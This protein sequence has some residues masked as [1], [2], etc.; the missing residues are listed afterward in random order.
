MIIDNDKTCIVSFNLVLP[1]GVALS[2]DVVHSISPEAV[3]VLDDMYLRNNIFVGW[4][5]SPD[6]QISGYSDF[7][8]LDNKTAQSAYWYH[9]LRGT[10]ELQCGKAKGILGTLLVSEIGSQVRRTSDRADNEH[11]DEIWSRAQNLHSR[12]PQS[13]DTGVYRPLYSVANVVSSSSPFKVRVG[14]ASPAAM[15]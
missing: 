14:N 3:E 6:V 9:I 2:A 11:V 15:S 5:T 13:R 8:L 10:S 1:I 12:V 7:Q 4:P